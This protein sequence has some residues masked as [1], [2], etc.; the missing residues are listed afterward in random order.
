M[1]LSSPPKFVSVDDYFLYDG[2]IWYSFVVFP[3]RCSNDNVYMT[4]YLSE[5]EYTTKLE[6]YI[7]IA[8]KFPFMF[9]FHIMRTEATEIWY[10]D[11]EENKKY[12]EVK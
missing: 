7:Q 4:K 1:V 11:A 6:E 5:E 10:C 2:T 9:F 12:K 8:G 3:G